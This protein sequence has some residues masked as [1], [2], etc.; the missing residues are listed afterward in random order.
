MEAQ[1]FYFLGEQAF[2]DFAELFI[3]NSSPPSVNRRIDAWSAWRNSKQ[4]FI[5]LRSELH[6]DDPKNRASWRRDRCMAL[7]HN[8]KAFSGGEHESDSSKLKELLFNASIDPD[9]LIDK[10]SR[11]LIAL[12]I[13]EKVLE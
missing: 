1:G 6:L 7:Y 3:L 4:T 5:G 8:L 13:G 11:D 12:K 2:L 9:I 10:L